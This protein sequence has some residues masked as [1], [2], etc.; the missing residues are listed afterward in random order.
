M[1]PATCQVP[2][3][4]LSA[5]GSEDHHME[6]YEVGADAYIAKPFHTHYLKLRIRKL[7]EYRQKLHD[8]FKNDSAEDLLSGVRHTDRR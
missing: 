8:L 7:L 5:R 1:T 2:F 4:L 6:G 3:I